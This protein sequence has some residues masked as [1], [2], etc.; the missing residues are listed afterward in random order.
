MPCGNGAQCGAE[1]A[2][3]P[4]IEG[5]EQSSRERAWLVAG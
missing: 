5:R 4:A 1:C 3:W 2:M